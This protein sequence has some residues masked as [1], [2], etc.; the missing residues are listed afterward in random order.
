MK[1]SEEDGEIICKTIWSIKT[2]SQ[3]DYSKLVSELSYCTNSL[4][5]SR[6]ASEDRMFMAF[7]DQLNRY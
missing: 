1:I 4:E 7:Q 2:F 6:V 5:Y 3:Q